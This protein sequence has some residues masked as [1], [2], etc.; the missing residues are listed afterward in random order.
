[1][2]PR[3]GIMWAHQEQA[4]N[5]HGCAIGNAQTCDSARERAGALRKARSTQTVRQLYIDLKLAISDN[6]LFKVTR[7]TEAAGLTV[8]Y[9]FL[10]HLLAEFAASIPA[11][12]RMKGRRLRSF[13]KKAYADLLPVEILKKK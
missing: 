4:Y 3:T 6:D 1:M 13:F 8:R 5:S 2:W 12:V 10:D 9:P 7:T 11:N